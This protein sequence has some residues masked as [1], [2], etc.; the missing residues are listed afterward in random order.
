MPQQP[1]QRVELGPKHLDEARRAAV[2]GTSLTF[3]DIV[4]RGLLLRVR[5]SAV[6]WTLRWNG[7]TRSLGRLGSTQGPM[8]P[9]EIR[10]VKAAREMAQK[11]RALL[12]DGTDPAAFLTGKAA[13]KDDQGAKKAAERKSA[14]AAGRW[15]W[16]VLAEKYATYLSNPRTT[17]RGIRKLP[18][19][20]TAAE[21]RRYLTMQETAPLR[22]KLLSELYI[23]DLED[24]RDHCNDTGRSAASRQFVA[25]ARAAFSFAK[26]KHSRKAGLEG[27]PKWWLEVGKLDETIPAPRTRYPSLPALATALFVS[28]TTRIMPGREQRRQT[29]EMVLCGLWWLALTAQRA[30]A[31]LSLRRDHVLPWPD[32]PEG[33]KVAFFPAS[34]MKSKRPHSIPIPPRVVLLIERAMRLG[35]D[36]T[37]VFSAVRTKGEEKDVPLTKSSPGLLLQRL[38]GRAADPKAERERLREAE[39]KGESVD[40]LPDLL[41]EAKVPYF[42]VHDLRR[43]FATKCGDLKVRAD[44]VSAVLDHEI[45]IGQASTLGADITRLAYDY[46]QRLELK[47]LAMEAWTDALFAACDKAWGRD[48]KSLL[49]MPMHN[50]PWYVQMASEIAREAASAAAAAERARAEA[51]ANRP[52]GRVDL[53]SLRAKMAENDAADDLHWE[54]PETS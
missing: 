48:R 21:A 43:T 16:E 50:Q 38:R 49:R 51:K 3:A 17:A 54:I 33:W 53:K 47:K 42:T 18:S 26:Q 2:L 10:T 34:V 29:S 23:G 4:E 7:H 32:G 44:A 37:F 11:V 5:G 12:K 27:V 20:S 14:I 19:L 8:A 52:Q 40:T 46:S 15:T 1:T 25:Y 30:S 39:E 28:E 41:Q 45:S 13:D 9:G 22:G 31:G 36:A 6:T 24:V 35:G